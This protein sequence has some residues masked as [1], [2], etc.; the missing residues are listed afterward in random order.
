[1][2]ASIHTKTELYALLKNNAEHIRQFGVSSIGV[3]GSFRHDAAK[4]S[5]DVDFLVD[6]EPS[7]KHTSI[8][9]MARNG[10]NTKYHY[11]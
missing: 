4:T 3:F 11:S 2:S 8:C 7:K 9:K 5:S 6:F 10:R 1:M